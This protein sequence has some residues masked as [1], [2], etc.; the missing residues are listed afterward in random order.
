MTH[1]AFVISWSAG[2]YPSVFGNFLPFIPAR[3][4]VYLAQIANAFLRG[5]RRK[6]HPTHVAHQGVATDKSKPVAGNFFTTTLNC[7]AQYG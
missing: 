1:L 3:T 5:A 2:C 4:L 6:A 7:Q